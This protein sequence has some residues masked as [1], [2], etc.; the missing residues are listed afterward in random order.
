[1]LWLH[2]G[3]ILVLTD[4]VMLSLVRVDLW[5][6]PLVLQWWKYLLTDGKLFLAGVCL[7][8]GLSRFEPA[9]PF[10]QSSRVCFHVENMCVRVYVAIHTHVCT[11]LVYSNNP[12]VCVCNILKV[13]WVNYQ[14]YWFL[15]A[16]QMIV[17]RI[18]LCVSHWLAG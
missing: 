5:N 16:S 18:L 14:C 12:K 7:A 13:S 15:P 1:M 11:L 2:V 10:F 3:G 6:C 8:G 4:H 17:V 9:E